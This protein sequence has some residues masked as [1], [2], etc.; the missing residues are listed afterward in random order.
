M[1]IICSGQLTKEQAQQE[2]KLEYYSDESCKED[3][4]YV[5]KKLDISEE[6]FNGYMNLPIKKHSDYPNY[7]K[8]HYKRQQHF[9]I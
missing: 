3:M 8:N 9:L 6:T 2:L 7:T 1:E 4:E 5:L